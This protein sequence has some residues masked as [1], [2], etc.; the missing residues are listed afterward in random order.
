MTLFEAYKNAKNKLLD[1]KIDNAEF[2]AK[3]LLLF[4]FALSNTDYANRKCEPCDCAR[5]ALFEDLTDR[6]AGGE[7][8]QYILGKWDFFGNE[9]IVDRGCL[10]PRTETEIIVKAALSL[11]IKAPYFVD[12]CTGS[13]CIGISFAKRCEN[14]NGLLLDISDD[15]L[16]IAK[17]N[18]EANCVFNVNCRKFD[19]FSDSLPPELDLLMSNPP[20]ISAKDMGALQKEVRFEPKIALYGG[21]D[22]LD[23][24]RAI[25]SKHIKN[26]KTGSYS[27]LEVGIG[28]AGFVC[29]MLKNADTEVLDIIK[30]D[31]GIERTLLAKKK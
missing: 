8:L 14:A 25:A 5:L 13:G 4:A 16:R 24:Y 9:F 18:I 10:I 19:V 11:E 1:A 29:D 23:F 17:R 12:L 22:G 27:I 6:R 2:D 28:Q 21:E 26:M 3:Q 7:P 30:D 20:Y 31:G 15:A